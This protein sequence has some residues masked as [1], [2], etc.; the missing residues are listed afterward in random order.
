MPNPHDIECELHDDE[1]TVHICLIKCHEQ[2]CNRSFTSQQS[3]LSHQRHSQEEGHGIRRLL[4]QISVCNK[5]IVCDTTFRTCFETGQHLTR[6]WHAGRCLAER[7][8]EIYEYKG[9]KTLTCPVCLDSDDEPLTFADIQLL[10]HHLVQHIPP[11]HN[12][13]P[14]RVVEPKSTTASSTV[15]PKS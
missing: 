3:L 11:T 8:R 12:H 15:K 10:K 4:H 5:C 6:S 13:G 2:T 14:I 7:T 1:T 9:P